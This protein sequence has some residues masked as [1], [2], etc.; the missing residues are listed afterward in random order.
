MGQQLA[1]PCACSRGVA[2]LL[3]GNPNENPESS[4]V[5]RIIQITDVYV[6]ENFPHL[7][8]LIKEKRAEL[9]ARCGGRTISM[10]TGDFLAPYLLSSLD[11]GFGMMTMLNGTP[12]DYLTWGN[13]EDDI[14]HA[15]VMRREGEY[16]GCW[17]NTNMQ[18]HES[19]KDS[20]CQV[21]AAVVEVSSRDG[22]NKRKI[23]LLGIL[24]NSPSLYKP[25][26][27]G[28]A[29]IED[30]WETI[31]RYKVKMEQ[32]RG[33][34]LVIPLC[35][36]Y[37]P[38][39]EHTC[40]EFDFPLILSGHDH[41]VVDRVVEGTRLLKPGLDGHKAFMVD[42]AW[43][44]AI[45]RA[46]EIQ[47]ELLT[48]KQ[49]EPDLELKELAEKA[50]SVLDPLRRT[51]LAKISSSYRPLTS[52]NSRGCRVSMGTYMLSR[53]RDAMNMDDA[54]GGEPHVHCALLKG[55]NVR[56]GREY[57]DDEH[58][59][60]E[61]LQSELEETKEVVVVPVPGLVLRTGLRETWDQPNPGWMQ[62]DDGVEVDK[63][64]FV[65]HI[66]G[67][68][69]DLA[70]TY[71]VASISDFWRKRDAPTIGA[72][73]E[74]HPELLPEP[75]SGKPIHWLLI[76]FFAMEIWTRIW[77]GLHIDASKGCIDDEAFRCIDKD[78]DGVLS[79]QDLKHAVED[80][81]G[82]E[83]FAG[84][85][86]I[87]DFMFNEISAFRRSTSPSTG[88][89]ITQKTLGEAAKHWSGTSLSSLAAGDSSEESDENGEAKR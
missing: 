36:L 25:N 7:R 16:K 67:K 6:L 86:V 8:T 28:G 77:K 74:L 78:G 59:T 46:P 41:H 88:D 12:I 72:Y 21:D 79:R 29:T 75:D 9:D 58:L 32:E 37:E 45:S 34:D 56:G 63:D 83:T 54:V 62:M 2:R 49:W 1:A 11:K 80:I 24:S 33:C 26:A 10:L 51:Q 89:G 30:P 60:L 87:I 22:S 48:V 42:I 73:F 13:H 19:F 64:G 55:G 18:S 43:P 15:D 52:F 31:A 76:R 27:F 44:S 23:G 38:Q 66:A 40:K 35:H 70:A 81:A 20:H 17:I 47:A 53:I 61:V 69:L 68:P 71:R 50:Y 5:L 84:Q 14:S 82:Y 57:G 3:G 65:T 85:D 4:V 39:D